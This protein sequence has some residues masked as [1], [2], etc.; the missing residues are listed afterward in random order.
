MKKILFI[1]YTHSL[2]GGAEKIL[3]NIVNGLVDKADY[4]ISVLEYACF[5]KK[6]EPLNSRINVLK[7]IVDMSNSSKLE[8]VF[9]MLLV[10]LFPC[11]LRK[12]YITD[13]YDAVISFNYQIPSFLTPRKKSVYNIQWTH[14]DLYDLKNQPFKRLLQSISF[15]KAD[16][17]VAISENTKNSI[18][19]IFPQYKDKIRIIYNGT[20]IKSIEALSNMSTDI[21]LKENSIIFLGRLEPN[22]NPLK[23]I[24]YTERLIK[25]ENLD[26]N[27]Y[28]L[29]TGVQQEEVIGYIN[30]IGMEDRIKALGY[31]SE[32]Y[33]IIKQ[34]RAVCLLSNSEGFPT[35]F[36]EGL[37]LGKPF[38]S[39][40]I[41]GVAELSNNGK[42][43]IIV[44]N[45]E[46]FRQAVTNIIFDDKKYTQMVVDCKEHIKQFSY[47]KQI[48]NII[49]LIENA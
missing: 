4:E 46:D 30:S 25:E 37:S 39:S 7:P 10:H 11:I 6:K 42:C 48:D 15:K 31:I 45:Y 41:G 27:L 18:L 22:K 19:D 21:K 16:K 29:G 12:I 35:V 5:H 13:N 34:S 36:A 38:I 26:V 44:N 23:L 8:R 28:L 1:T 14:G 20:D 47:D 9:K 24:K 32:P 3:T 40:E 49:K 33:P 43:G 17:I 2:G